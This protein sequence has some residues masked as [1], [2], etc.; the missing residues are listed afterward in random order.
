MTKDQD[1]NAAKHAGR[2]LILTP[3]KDTESFLDGYFSLLESLTYP[4]DRLSLGI[5]AGYS[6][7]NSF[8][9]LQRLL[10]MFA[11]DFRRKELVKLDLGVVLPPNVPRYEAVYQDACRAVLPAPATSSCSA[12]CATRIGCYGSMPTSSLSRATSYKR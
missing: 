10:P 6:R 3:M 12:R 1:L 4:H 11:T 9:E 8:A 2:V 7:D 5:L